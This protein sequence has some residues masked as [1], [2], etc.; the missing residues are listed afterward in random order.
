MSKYSKTILI[1][2]VAV[3]VGM[4]VLWVMTPGTG[5]KPDGRLTEGEGIEI[6]VL[7]PPQTVNDPLRIREVYVEGKTYRRTLNYGIEAVG[8]HQSW[9]LGVDYSV[10]YAGHTIIDSEIEKNDGANVVAK[11]TVR[12]AKTESARKQFDGLNIRLGERVHILLSLLGTAYEIP[13]GASQL[14][15][16]YVNSILDTPEAREILKMWPVQTF[17]VEAV[18]GYVFRIYFTDGKGVTDIELVQAPENREY[19]EK[20]PF[21]DEV[22]MRDFANNYNPI[23][24]VAIFPNEEVAVGSSWQVSG[25]SFPN[26]MSASMFARLSDSISIRRDADKDGTAILAVPEQS[27]LSFQARPKGKNIR[28]KISMEGDM[29]YD[30]ASRLFIRANFYG[31]L[32]MES[33]ST[34]HFLFPSAHKLAPQYAFQY[35]CEVVN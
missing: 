21:I 5:D 16:K 29:Q 13:P 31:K 22:V 30:P 4:L 14:A 11:V 7:E 9:G 3:V 20:M 10:L 17:H 19:G 8:Q 28:A 23:W 18:E 25:Q 33:M 35:A 2:G 1:V 6:R 15:E 24:D 27:S 26:L 34:D 12:E 32:P